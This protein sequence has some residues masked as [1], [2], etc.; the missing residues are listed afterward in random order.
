M[1]FKVAFAQNLPA[2]ENGDEL[3]GAGVLS[4]TADIQGVTDVPAALDVVSS[5]EPTDHEAEA[6]LIDALRTVDTRGAESVL[7]AVSASEGYAALTYPDEASLSEGMAAVTSDPPTAMHS[8]V[9][10]TETR[11]WKVHIDV[12]PEEP[13]QALAGMVQRIL[14]AHDPWIPQL[15]NTFELRMDYSTIGLF[16][17][18]TVSGL[19]GDEMGPSAD[20]AVDILRAADDC[21]TT[22][23]V[24]RAGDST[25]AIG[26]VAY[27]CTDGHLN[28]SADA[29][30][31]S[32][33][34][35][36]VNNSALAAELLVEARR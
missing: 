11:R 3:G 17:T 16:D 31:T 20:A 22:P 4:V 36:P 15:E 19:P 23:V 33:F 6:R 26:F 28:V 30:I 1:T 34:T 27:T 35:E 7:L 24:L 21:G 18:L 25:H 12:N 13:S 10:Y 8:V 32:A 29:E 9:F 5:D 14:A 2:D